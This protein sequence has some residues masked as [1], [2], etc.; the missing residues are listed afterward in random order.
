MRITATNMLSRYSVIER[1]E[2]RLKIL[3]TVL[4]QDYRKIIA[5]LKREAVETDRTYNWLLEA[6]YFKLMKPKVDILA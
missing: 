5:D 4:K 6:K 3:C 1:N 2:V